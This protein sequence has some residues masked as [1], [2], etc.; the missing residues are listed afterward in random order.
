[1]RTL[2]P[3]QIL[4]GTTLRKMVHTPEP[5]VEGKSNKKHDWTSVK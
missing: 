2:D 3:I 5:V 4:Q 1:M